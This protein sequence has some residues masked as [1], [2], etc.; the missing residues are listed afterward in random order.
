MVCRVS[1]FTCICRSASS[2]SC[3]WCCT[4]KDDL[5]STCTCTHLI[6]LQQVLLCQLAYSSSGHSPFFTFVRCRCQ[7]SHL[8]ARYL[9]QTTQQCCSEC[10]N[11][12]CIQQ[13]TQNGSRHG[14]IFRQHLDAALSL[15]C[16][17]KAEHGSGQ[18]L[19]SAQIQSWLMHRCRSKFSAGIPAIHA[20]NCIHDHVLQECD[21]GRFSARYVAARR[22]ALQ[23]QQAGM[24]TTQ[25]GQ[26]TAN[27][28]T[29]LA[30]V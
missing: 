30:G 6:Q 26:L 18:Q 3:R 23:R 22:P 7:S 4:Q 17:D 2:V 29:C 14:S 28:S 19:A 16:L 9:K 11:L 24:S 13:Q 15:P 21:Q 20:T 25:L 1:Q 8:G 10:G 27:L 12:V 5:Y